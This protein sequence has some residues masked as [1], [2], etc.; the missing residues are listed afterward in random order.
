M[1]IAISTRSR[2]RY[3]SLGDAL[4]NA[5]V[6][7]LPAA[8][9]EEHKRLMVAASRVGMWRYLWPLV[10]F[11]DLHCRLCLGSDIRMSVTGVFFVSGTMASILTIDAAVKGENVPLAMA[12]F[13]AIWA[14]NLL[15]VGLAICLA[16]SKNAIR[17]AGY[18]RSAALD[19]VDPPSP[20]AYLLQRAKWASDNLQVDG[21]PHKIVIDYF[22]RDPF[23]RIVR[24]G[25][26]FHG[27]RSATVGAW[28]T[29]TKLDRI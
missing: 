29:N 12:V 22:D 14:L 18:W 26:W 19:S 16:H 25:L 28:G 17:A 11:I 9:V 4:R 5:G 3:L 6:P 27:E 1:T 21:I 13:V 2:S 10:R 8:D 7:V 23:I 20:P 24:K 15:I